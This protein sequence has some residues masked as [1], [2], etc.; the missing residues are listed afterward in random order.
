MQLFL[1][2]ERPKRKRGQTIQQQLI[3]LFGSVTSKLSISSTI[4]IFSPS[5]LPNAAVASA[6][7]IFLSLFL[8]VNQVLI[9]RSEFLWMEDGVLWSHRFHFNRTIYWKKERILESKKKW[10]NHEKSAIFFAFF[11]AFFFRDFSLFFLKN[12]KIFPKKFTKIFVQK[13]VTEKFSKSNFSTMKKYFSS[14][15]F[16]RSRI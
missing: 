5:F 12:S 15:F 9:L 7:F 8:E 2:F 13:K 4:C 3:S 11:F 1:P 10:K 6:K 14:K 16:L